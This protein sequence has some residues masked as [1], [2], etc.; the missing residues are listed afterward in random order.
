M[1]TKS[2]LQKLR[3]MIEDEMHRETEKYKSKFSPYMVVYREILRMIE[4]I[5]AE[6]EKV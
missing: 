6:K 4:S 5:E 1:T 3:D 2:D